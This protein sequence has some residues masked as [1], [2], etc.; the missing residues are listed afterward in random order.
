MTVI[1][2]GS[3]RFDVPDV[4][5]DGATLVGKGADQRGAE[6]RFALRYIELKARINEA[7]VNIRKEIPANR[8]AG[9]EIEDAPALHAL[10]HVADI[11]K[12]DVPFPSAGTGESVGESADL[13]MALE[14]EDP[15][16]AQP[17]HETSK[18]ETA[19]AGA[20]DD[21]VVIAIVRHAFPLMAPPNVR[22]EAALPRITLS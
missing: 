10:A 9:D 18:S 3:G 4:A 5:L 8:A 17:R 19:D 13:E 14:N 16:A 6:I 1:A 2:S 20:D 11:V 22:H 7:V 21:G 15:P 12:A